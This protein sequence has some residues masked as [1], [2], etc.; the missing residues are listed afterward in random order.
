M[1]NV[2]RLKEILKS[3]LK[4]DLFSPHRITVSTTPFH[5]VDRSSILR[6]GTNLKHLKNNYINTQNMEKNRTPH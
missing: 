1:K 5:G 2:R 4:D 3:K 6:E